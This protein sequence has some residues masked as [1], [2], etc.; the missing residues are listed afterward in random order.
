MFKALQ[1]SQ[2][3]FQLNS[4]D[5]SWKEGVLSSWLAHSPLMVWVSILDLVSHSFGSLSK[6]FK[7]FAFSTVDPIWL[8]LSLV[9]APSFKP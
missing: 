7:V 3:L 5:N 1:T 9:G 2:R 4:C 6:G 8:G